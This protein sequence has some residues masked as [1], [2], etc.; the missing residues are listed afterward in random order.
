M[1]ED[2]DEPRGLTAAA[3]KHSGLLIGVF[4]LIGWCVMLWAMFGDVL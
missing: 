2:D 3:R 4:G 1:T